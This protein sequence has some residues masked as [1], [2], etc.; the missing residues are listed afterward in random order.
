M[1]YI[2]PFI[3]P[4]EGEIMF[5]QQI[6]PFELPAVQGQKSGMKLAVDKLTDLVADLGASNADLHARAASLQEAH[7]EK[8][9]LLQDFI[10]AFGDPETDEV[11]KDALTKCREKREKKAEKDKQKSD[12]ID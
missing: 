9:A 1:W 10:D 4:H 5:Q 12:K 3:L 6:N 7:N 8:S 11:L 2:L